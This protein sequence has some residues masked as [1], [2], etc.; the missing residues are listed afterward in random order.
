MIV[1]TKFI[2]KYLGDAICQILSFFNRNRSLDAENRKYG[3][4]LVIQLWGIGE[5]ILTLPAIEALRKKFSK[6]EIDVLATSR[7]KDIFFNNHNVNN[8]ISLELNPFS[9]LGFIVK[10]IK[11]RQ[12]RV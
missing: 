5:T 11:Q 9:I 7:N 12:V 3:K 6:A 10:N 4:I 8:V 2:D 1:I